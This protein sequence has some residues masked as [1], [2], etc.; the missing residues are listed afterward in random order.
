MRKIKLTQT[1]SSIRRT[2]RQ[3]A[4]LAGLGIRGMG[5][6]VEVQDTPPNR[7]MINKVDFMLK[8]EV[9]GNS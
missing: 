6:S 5:D 1:R 9:I 4:C 2:A 8:V 7:G 3:K